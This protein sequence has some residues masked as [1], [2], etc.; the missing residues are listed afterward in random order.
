VGLLFAKWQGCLSHRTQGP[1]KEKEDRSEAE[2][3]R[4]TGK[5]KN[6]GVKKNSI[7]NKSGDRESGIY[8]G[9]AGK[10]SGESLFKGRSFTREKISKDTPSNPSK[11]SVGNCLGTAES[12]VARKKKTLRKERGTKDQRQME[13]SLF[14]YQIQ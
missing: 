9:R 5:E 1:L 4:A 10:A 13:R 3:F 7:T 11:T 2:V 8:N 14:E 12:P 6:I